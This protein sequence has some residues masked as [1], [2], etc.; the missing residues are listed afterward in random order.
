MSLGPFSSEYQF[1]LSFLVLHNKE[2]MTWS[3][4]QLSVHG[5]DVTR[6]NFEKG[7]ATLCAKHHADIIHGLSL[8]SL[9]VFDIRS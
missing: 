5:L 2:A 8:F 6:E 4:P 9:H 3:D 1:R 7:K